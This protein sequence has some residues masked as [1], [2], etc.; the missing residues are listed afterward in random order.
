MSLTSIFGFGQG[1]ENAVKDMDVQQISQNWLAI[2]N[3]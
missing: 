3:W 1:G 2:L